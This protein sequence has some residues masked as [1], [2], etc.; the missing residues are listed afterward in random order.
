MYGSN[1]LSETN[2]KKIARVA[3]KLFS[4]AMPSVNKGTQSVPRLIH[5]SKIMKPSP[6]VRAELN[7]GKTDQV[8]IQPL[9]ETN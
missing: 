5:T 1:P 4:I 3:S 6:C 2:L 9:Y 8:W 7:Q